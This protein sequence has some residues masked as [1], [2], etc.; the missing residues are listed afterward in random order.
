MAHWHIPISAHSKKGTFQKQHIPKWAHS[1][2]G[3]FQKG[4][5]PKMAHSKKGTFQIWHI[6]KRAH[7]K[8]GTHSHSHSHNLI[9][10]VIV[11][12]RDVAKFLGAL[13][14]SKKEPYFRFWLVSCSNFKNLYLAKVLFLLQL[15]KLYYFFVEST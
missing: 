14:A 4:H 10:I 5:I 11:T 1:K 7:S 12:P 8:N 3:T 13:E 6:P 15:P 9:F 2:Y